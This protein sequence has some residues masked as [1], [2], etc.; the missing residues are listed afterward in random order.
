MPKSNCYMCNKLAV[1]RHEAKFKGK[2][3]KLCS[4]GCLSAFRF[5]HDLSIECCGF[6]LS[7]FVLSGAQ[8]Q[9]IQYQGSSKTFCSDLCVNGFKTK[10]Q[11]IVKCHWCDLRKLNFDMIDTSDANKTGNMFCSMNC[12]SRS[13]NCS[14]T[15]A[16]QE[17][18]TAELG[19]RSQPWYKTRHSSKGNFVIMFNPK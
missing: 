15:Q 10:H 8:V 3:H 9:T 16:V 12:V 4:D 11:R 13:D 5:M 19:S 2:S 17:Q 14:N 7:M 6:C 1:I 18:S